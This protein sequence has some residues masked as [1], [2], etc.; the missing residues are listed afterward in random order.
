MRHQTH[1]MICHG[2]SCATVCDGGNKAWNGAGKVAIGFAHCEIIHA[3]AGSSVAGLSAYITRDSRQD[4]TT[5]EAFSF[6]HKNADLIDTGVILPDGAAARLEDA[7]SLWGTAMAAET[8]LDRQTKEIRFKKGAQVAKH[9]VLALPKECTDAERRDLTTGFVRDE[10]VRHGVA[11]EWAIHAP[12][13]ENGNWHAHV[14]VSTRRL[15]GERFGKKCQEI[16]PGF[17]RGANGQRFVSEDDRLTE[18]WAETQTRFFKERGLAVTVDPYG[19][20]LSKQEHLGPTW[21]MADSRKVERQ[22]VALAEAEDKARHDPAAVLEAVTQRKATFTL[23]EVER[24][25]RKA[26][27][28]GDDFGQARTAVLMHPDLLPL[29]RREDDG[30]LTE[31]GRFTTRTVRDQ[32]RQAMDAAAHVAARRRRVPLRALEHA[33]GARTL[34]GEQRAALE[35][36]CGPAGLALIEG[37]AGAGKSYTMGAIREAHEQGGFRVIGLAPTNTVAQDLR[38]ALGAG[39][40][41]TSTVHLA[42]LRQEKGREPA[43]DARTA[44]LVDEA[45]MLDARTMGRLLARADQCGAKVILVGDDRQLAS[46]ERGGL[47]AEMRQRHGAAEIRDIRRQAEDW[48]RQASRDFSEG[49]IGEGLAA[50]DQRGFVR[51]TNRTDEAKAALV[52]DWA[53]AQR[54]RP[55][56]L[57]FIYASTNREVDDLNRRCRA[58]RVARGEVAAGERFQTVR[59]ELA[60]AAGDRL[61]F[62]GNDRKAGIYNGM[63]GNIESAGRERISVRLDGGE[64]VSFNPAKFDQWGH[65]YAG[66]VYRGQGKTQPEVLALYDNPAGWNARAAYVGMTRHK[67]EVR[68]YV[69][70]DMAANREVLAR[71]MSQ[72]DDVGASLRYEEM[73]AGAVRPQIG[74]ST[75][76]KA[77]D[78]WASLDLSGASAAVEQAVW[79]G[80]SVSP[81]DLSMQPEAAHV[82]SRAAFEHSAGKVA[83]LKRGKLVVPPAMREEQ[84]R[85]YEAFRGDL[86][87][88]AR[89][90]PQTAWDVANAVEK[91]Q[92]EAAKGLTRDIAAGIAKDRGAMQV[93]RQEAPAAAQ[94]IQR[95]LQ[96]HAHDLS[97]GGFSL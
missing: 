71:Q 79:A 93:L 8:T 3:A 23:R 68:L 10:F 34:D 38:A 59:G 2:K 63:A 13:G 91:A 48:Q 83:G 64:T 65:G 31:I 43:W 41:Q 21:H 78:P 58:L 7:G 67:A 12:D 69:G 50:Y 52:A 16:N 24:A 87:G 35:H 56:A 49:R 30:G 72:A 15:E 19:S 82:R 47:F 66:T 46:V 62:Y 81:V 84:K 18:R 95:L 37:R 20:K 1:Y 45:A 17:A 27:L 33:A 11:A 57:R 39:I 70:R 96:Q 86:R 73:P 97:R 77:P 89:Q 90:E 14:L 76:A 85:L 22:S 36:A 75:P 92:P 28:A 54:E 25:L 44:L 55:E 40:A 80:V 88:L 9:I 94:A 29:A 53:Q 42:L 4:L 26:G 61:Q 6:G 32:E 51:W 60:A 74:A 5:G